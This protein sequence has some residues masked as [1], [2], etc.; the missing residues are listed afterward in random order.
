MVEAPAR[1][2][3]RSTTEDLLSPDKSSVHGQAASTDNVI[4]QGAGPSAVTVNSSPSLQLSY[5]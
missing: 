1:P 2:K 4:Y 5:A 3:K